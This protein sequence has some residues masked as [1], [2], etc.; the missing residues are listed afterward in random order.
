MNMKLNKAKTKAQVV[1]ETT[2]AFMVLLALM[3]GIT[4]VFLYFTGTLAKRQ[5]A[6]QKLRKV[7]GDAVVDTSSIDEDLQKEADFV[8]SL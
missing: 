6:Y 5:V 1:I 8:P 2:V 7:E 3:I 4:K